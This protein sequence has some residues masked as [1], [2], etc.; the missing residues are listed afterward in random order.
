MQEN[1]FRR[2]RVICSTCDLI[3]V[4]IRHESLFAL[5]LTTPVQGKIAHQ[6]IKISHRMV[7]QTGRLSPL[8]PK[9]C[10]LDHILGQAA[11]AYD[12]LGVTD[13]GLSAFDQRRRKA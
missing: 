5:Q 10:I 9:P 3:E 12:F 4:D 11:V 2:A 7:R 6:P 1:G 8:Q 13:Q